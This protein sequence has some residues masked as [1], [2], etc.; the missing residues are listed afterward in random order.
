MNEDAE[1]LPDDVASLRA[2]VIAQRADFRERE[3]QLTS[4][5][6]DITN[7]L[8]WEKEKYLSLSARY[9]GSSSE[10]QK[11]IPGQGVFEFNEAEAHAS[12]GEKPVAVI[13]IAAHERQKRGRKIR[14][15]DIETVED[16]HDLPEEEKR[17][18]CCGELRPEMQPETS[19]EY[20]LIP[21]HVVR[22][23]HIRKQYGQCRC[24]Q[25]ARSGQK[26]V[27]V[28]PGVAKI[29][30][31]SEF[32]NQTIAFFMIGKYADAVPFYRMVKIL[33]RSG[34][35]VS[36]GTLCN[37]AIR[38]GRA[39]EDLIDRMWEDVRRSPVI[40]MD[41]T[42][43]Q[44]L[45]EMNRSAESQSYMWLTC[46]YDTGQK[47]VLFHYHPTRKKLVAEEALKGFS[48]YLQTDGY[49]GYTAVGERDGITHVG[50]FAHIRRAFVDAQKVCGPGGKADEMIELIAKVY[51]IERRLRERYEKQELDAHAF[52]E[53]RKREL[54]SVFT[55]IRLWL[56][57]MSLSVAPSTK[58][59]EAIRYAQGQ[60]EKAVRF[61]DHELL[62]PDTNR[63]ENAIRP[64]VVG[65]KN[66]EF[67]N[68]PLGAH[69]SAAIYSLIETAK[70]NGHDPY[71]YLCY[72]FKELPKA[73]TVEDKIK[74]LPYHL[75]PSAY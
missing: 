1:R 48:G 43:V 49:E 38:V 51:A 64:F 33:A 5:I 27:L 70:A 52:I 11:V 2:L 31:K 73:K 25:F 44:V 58:L 36:R 29:V 39:L 62:T 10:K 71:K 47:I 35:E 20:D 12:E 67:C 61:V 19:V 6:A 63:A 46:G 17:C 15:E 8:I 65:R 32:T 74:L 26:S 59:G 21:A 68:T 23:L 37:L 4:Q 56:S 69:A 24:E 60:L 50:C 9:F 13:A 57:K 66:W 28:A 16:V 22:K 40:L 7:Q 42:T 14:S 30:P 75:A 54:E 53:K 18:A 55:E 72:L 3:K 41:E 45:H 34:L